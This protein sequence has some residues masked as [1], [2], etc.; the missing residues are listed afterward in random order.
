MQRRGPSSPPIELDGSRATPESPGVTPD[1]AGALA[2]AI[3]DLPAGLRTRF[4]PAPTGYLHLGHVANALVVWQVAGGSG[5][6][7][8]LRIED[9][10]RQR[11]RPEYEIA[12]LDDL[13]ALGFTPDEPSID[14]LRAGGPSAYRQSDDGSV[15][16][17]A[18][19][20]LERA[21]H[22]YACDCSRQMFR[23]WASA[24][25][26][27]WSGPG[28]PGGCSTR[29]LARDQRGVTLRAALDREAES[30]T[31][32]VHGPQVGATAPRGDPALRDQHGNWSYT[33]CVVVDDL[34]HGIDLV[35]R[36]DDLLEATPVQISLGR[37]L[38]RTEPPR[39]LHHPLIHRPD[40]RK[41]S[42]ADGDTSI[43]SLL[44][45]GA[46][47]VTIRGRAAEAIGLRSS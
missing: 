47:A 34:R 20:E 36:G 39:F 28:C 27:P 5:G 6:S 19:A 12:L 26:R 29:G 21:G 17:G 10:D 42:K 41:L 25:D 22:V 32:L 40:G 3:R 37:L 4:A 33:L 38:G 31:D 30:W 44:E 18:V 45:S 9:H 1:F 46:S 16:A 14:A 7:V 24:N 43:R 11:C 35:I 8:V 23:A 2:A 15:Y 13:E